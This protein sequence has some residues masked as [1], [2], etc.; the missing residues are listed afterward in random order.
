[1]GKRGHEAARARY[2]WPDQA[3]LFVAQL[4]DWARATV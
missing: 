4:E 3:R 2:H 1:M